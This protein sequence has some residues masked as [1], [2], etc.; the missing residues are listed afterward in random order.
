MEGHAFEL[1]DARLAKLGNPDFTPLME[2][3][4]DL[5]VEGNR[6][7]VLSGIDGFDQPMKDLKY[8]GGKGK[9]T[10]ARKGDLF[11]YKVFH[12]RNRENEV[13]RP[14][15]GSRGSNAGGRDYRDATG[16]RLAPFREQSRVIA[17][18]KT[19]HHRNGNVWE[20]VGAWDSVISKKGVRFLPYH[21]AENRGNATFP[22]YDLRPVRKQERTKARSMMLAF[23][24]S[25]IKWGRG[26]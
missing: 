25:L 21:F 13:F 16:P 18:L 3:W 10:G 14:N 11:G 6:R 2:K 24:A 19:E 23:V 15:I 5:I 22:R 9:R 7:G 17:N 20:A 26:T 8:R 1:I 4:E 12:T